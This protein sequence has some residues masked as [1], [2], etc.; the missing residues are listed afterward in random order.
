MANN[1]ELAVGGRVVL[2]VTVDTRRMIGQL[3]KRVVACSLMAKRTILLFVLGPIVI[4]PGVVFEQLR[5][6]RRNDRRRRRL[7]RL[8][9]ARSHRRIRIGRRP[10]D[11]KSTRLNSSH[12]SISYA[13]FCLKKKNR[14]SRPLL[15]SHSYSD[16][17]RQ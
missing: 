11:R 2:P 9:F 15:H 16:Q 6:F 8:P 1:A 5:F 17:L 7:G 14:Q 10:S 13:V 3:R 12:V 4:E